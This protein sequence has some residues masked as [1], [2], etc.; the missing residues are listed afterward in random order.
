ML[1]S[2][3]FKF[4]KII[5]SKRF[6]ILSIFFQVIIFFNKETFE[7]FLFL[8]ISFCRFFI[9]F[10]SLDKTYLNFAKILDHLLRYDISTTI[11]MLRQLFNKKDIFLL[12]VIFFTFLISLILTLCKCIRMAKII[13][14][15]ATIVVIIFLEEY[16]NQHKI[17]SSVKF[18]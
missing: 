11:Y 9:I 5:T 15:L 13:F 18:L 12:L 1:L 17:S 6:S 8:F 3:S 14:A 2:N 10:C 4:L 16:Y 7:L